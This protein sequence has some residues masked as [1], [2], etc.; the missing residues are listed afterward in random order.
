[1][2]KWKNL[3]SIYE[4]ICKGSNQGSDSLFMFIN[5]KEIDVY[6]CRKHNNVFRD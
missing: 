3:E 2:G 4:T 6:L 1:M 5:C